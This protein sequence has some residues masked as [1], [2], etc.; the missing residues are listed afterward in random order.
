MT[1]KYINL[2]DTQ[3]GS[4]EVLGRFE[5]VER[6]SDKN[7]KKKYEKKVNGKKGSEKLRLTFGNSNNYTEGRSREKYE[8]PPMDTYEGEE[9]EIYIG[10]HR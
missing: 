10:Y 3:S 1:K 6:M 2:S 4:E 7:G 8:N 5:R 9:K